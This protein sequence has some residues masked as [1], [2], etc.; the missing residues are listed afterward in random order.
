MLQVC[1]AVIYHSTVYFSTAEDSVDTSEIPGVV[2]DTA[3]RTRLTRKPSLAR[4][5]ETPASMRETS[6]EGCVQSQMLW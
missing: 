4:G 1:N 5:A 3:A 6:M 2:K